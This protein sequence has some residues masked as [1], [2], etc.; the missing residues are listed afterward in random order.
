MKKRFT[1]ILAAI[2]LFSLIPLTAH[3]VETLPTDIKS[4]RIED[5]QLIYGGY[6][7][8]LPD[9]VSTYKEHTVIY[10]YRELTAIIGQ[11][12]I[13]HWVILCHNNTELQNG[14]DYNEDGYTI[15]DESEIAIVTMNIGGDQH[16]TYSVQTSSIYMQPQV[17]N[18]AASIGGQFQMKANWIESIVFSTVDI[19]YNGKVIVEAVEDPQDFGNLFEQFITEPI[20]GALEALFVPDENALQNAFEQL[21]EDFKIVGFVKETTVDIV[22]LFTNGAFDTP[23]QVKINLSDSEGQYD[24]GTGNVTVLDLSW[25]ARY[26]PTVDAMLSSIMLVIFAWRLWHQLPNIISG[27]AGAFILGRD[28]ASGNREKLSNDRSRK[29]ESQ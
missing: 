18:Q 25:Y 27:S 20:I 28:I 26:K 17:D 16:F 22:D 6:V 13:D 8:N 2:L 12:Y 9:S 11:Y 10:Q 23:P 21:E 5:N 14:Y 19:I 7:Y 3:A 24:Y 4:A 1:A 29:K 15:Y